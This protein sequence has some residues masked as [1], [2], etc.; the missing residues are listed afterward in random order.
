M[1]N[2][3]NIRTRNVNECLLCQKEGIPLYTGLPDRLFD[4]SGSWSFQQCV[5]CNLVWLS[6]RPITEDLGKTYATYMTHDVNGSK[7]RMEV[8]LERIAAS[9]LRSAQWF[10]LRQTGG[11][12]GSPS[13]RVLSWVPL[14]DD[15]ARRYV[16]NLNNGNGSELLDVGCG[17][18]TFIADMQNLGWKVNGVEPDPRAAKIAQARLGISVF[19]GMLHERN[20]E[21]NSFDAITLRHVIEHAEEPIAL[22]RECHRILKLGG[23]LSIATP[24]VDCLQHRLHKAAWLELDPPRHLHLFSMASLT[25]VLHLAIPDG[26]RIG[27]MRSLSVSAGQVGVMSRSIQR[28]GKWKTKHISPLQIAEALIYI[29]CEEGAKVFRPQAGEE[30]L[31]TIMKCV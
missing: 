16:M 25:K 19:P 3:Q 20:F 30:I 7:S 22:I 27:D 12:V 24:N 2:P 17:D 6:P 1:N 9:V 21:P 8:L 5:E 4:V 18:G 14:F 23:K 29:L 31:M 11:S 15:A 10:G 28:E 26:F 13:G